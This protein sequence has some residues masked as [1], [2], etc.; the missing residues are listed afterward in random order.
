[1]NDLSP[2]LLE[3]GLLT[4]A[5][6]ATFLRLSR[7][8]LY[9]LMERGDLP[10]VCI[11]RTR[12]IPRRAVLYLAARC[13]KGGWQTDSSGKAIGKKNGPPSWDR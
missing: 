10:F 5:E 13:L 9:G 8:T 7:S 12:R 4:V 2:K 11:G 1:M 3:D 6:A